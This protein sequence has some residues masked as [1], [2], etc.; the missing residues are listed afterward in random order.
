MSL[1]ST[2]VPISFSNHQ[3]L[4]GVVAWSRIDNRK[5]A[6]SIPAISTKPTLMIWAILMSPNRTKHCVYGYIY[7]YIPI[8][9]VFRPIRTHQYGSNHQDWFCA[10]GGDIY[11]T[12]Q[13]KRCYRQTISFMDVWTAIF[14]DMINIKMAN[15]I[16]HSAPLSNFIINN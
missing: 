10:D 6:G 15:I 16:Q 9:T 3:G 2:L 11:I 7:I 1:L 14:S 4:G 8:D 12:V 5:V 13:S